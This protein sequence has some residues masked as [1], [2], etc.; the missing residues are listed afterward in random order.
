[1]HRTKILL[2]DD[3]PENLLALQAMLEDL[4]QDLVTASSGDEAL[5]ALMV[6]EFALILLDVQMPGMD[7]FETAEC[8][9]ARE[10]TRD[11]PIIFLTAIDADPKHAFRGYSTGAVDFLTK[12]IDPVVLRT[13]VGVFVALHLKALRL[14]DEIRATEAAG[15][16]QL[17]RAL[18]GLRKAVEVLGPQADVSHVLF[19]ERS[20]GAPREV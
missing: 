9:K 5:K 15:A 16:D 8:I 10:R 19:P 2:V 18:A 14:R 3:R 12:P 11:I 1:M 20:D 13:K 7:G 4:E 6:D 17:A